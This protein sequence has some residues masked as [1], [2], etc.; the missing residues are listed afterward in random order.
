MS[1]GMMID[2]LGE[3][4]ATQRLEACVIENLSAG[5]VRTPDIGG[6]SKTSDVADDII[7]RLRS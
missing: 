6:T 5:E 4:A 1:A 7:A 3:S 2:F